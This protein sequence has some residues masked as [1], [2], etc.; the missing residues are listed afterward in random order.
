MSEYFAYFDEAG[1]TGGNFLHPNQPV[2][3]VGG[4]ILPAGST[5]GAEHAVQAHTALVAPQAKEL[6][7]LKH[8][9]GK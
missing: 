4:W 5:K 7:G 2:Y 1:N 3:V 9:K 6:H 8:L